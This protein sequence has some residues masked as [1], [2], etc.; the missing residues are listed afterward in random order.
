MKEKFKKVWECRDL[1]AAKE[2]LGMEIREDRSSGS[3]IVDQVKYLD[4]ILKRFDMQDA[5]PANTPLPEKY[6]PMAS[7]GKSNPR[8]RSQYQLVIGSL[9][10]LMLGTRPDIAFAVI[11]MSQFSANPTEDHLNHA[12]YIFRYLRGNR[13]YGIEYKRSSSLKVE[14]Y[15]D[16]DWASDKNDRKSCTGFFVLFNASPVS[17]VSRKQKT[18]ATSATE[19]EYMSLSD[20]SKQVCWATT[21]LKELTVIIPPVILYG[22]NMGSIFLAQN[23]AQERR[24]KHIDIRYHFIRECV[25]E[26]KVLEL[27]HV[28]TDKQLADVLTKSLGKTKFSGFRDFLV[29][30]LTRIKSGGVLRNET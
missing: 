11:K 28:P 5:N 22:D 9:L 23:P 27:R 29:K 17:W 8:L 25:Q 21:L 30:D 10:Y 4:K 12:K 14:A 18:V 19:A 26:R 24:T 3:L 13:N 6:E 20:A 1:G 7:T 15:S 2:Y 16:A